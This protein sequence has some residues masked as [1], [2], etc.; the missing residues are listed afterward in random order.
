MNGM[1]FSS[2]DMLAD[3]RAAYAEMLAGAGDMAAAAEMMSEALALAPGWAAGRFRLGEML[4][5]AGRPAEAVEA[6]RETLRLDPEDR[7]GATLKLGLAGAAQRIEA[8]PSG[9]VETLFDQYAGDFDAALVERLDYRVPELLSA[10]IRETRQGGWAHLIDLG[11]GTGLMGERLRAATS[12]V[13]GVDISSGMLRRAEQKGIYDRLTRADLQTLEVAEATADL[14]TAA[15]VFI[16]LGA[17]DRVIARTARMLRPGGLLA[18]SVERHDGPGDMTLRDSRRYA[19]SR[20]YVEDVLAR[21]GFAIESLREAELRKDRGEP[22]FGLIVAAKR[23]F[24][25]DA[26][27]RD[28]ITAPTAATAA[29]AGRRLS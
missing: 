4:D 8:A 29:P 7:F 16:Y 12:F 20:A 9:F 24:P 14:V 17:L 13:E 21:N 28:A 18:F 22:V 6:W 23:A 19:H 11:C 3:R 15:D 27:D 1:Q 2:G 5:A 10:A 25:A 26:H